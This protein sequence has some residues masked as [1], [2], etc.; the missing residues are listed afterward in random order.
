MRA[1][2]EPT[3]V[4]LFL[5]VAM[6]AAAGEPVLAQRS[7]GGPPGE[8]ARGGGPPDGGHRPPQSSD[9]G[10]RG[11][12]RSRGGYWSSSDGR[13]RLERYEAFVASM[14]TNRNG[15]IE[16]NEAQGGRGRMIR[17]LA[18]RAKIDGKF[19][20]SISR[21][22]EGLKKNYENR[23]ESK[24]KPKSEDKSSKEK[25]LVPAFGI[26][27]EEMPPVLEFGKAPP[28]AKTSSKAK[29]SSDPKSASS[30][31][32][33]SGSDDRMKRW[34]ESIIK[35]H[36]KN[37]NGKLE[38]DEWG[39]LRGDPK[40]TDRN[41][42]GV[43]TLD[44]MTERLNAYRRGRSRGEPSSRSSPRKSRSSSSDSDDSDGRKFYRSLTATERLPE[45]I[46]SWFV[47][48]DANGDG[49]VAMAEYSSRWTVSL[50]KRFT[51]IDRNGDGV[52]TPKESL[53]GP[54]QAVAP[55]K[56]DEPA[57]TTAATAKPE[58]TAK[59]ETTAKPE[60]KDQSGGMWEGW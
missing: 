38:K 15:R 50:A 13:S 30:S 35:Q 32:S 1:N 28:T 21:L 17:R 20:I 16:E 57:E 5:S 45:D 19:P 27:Q 23:D 7:R 43:I 14:D 2:W 24:S 53:E 11:S 48:K 3:I 12:G 6:V 52:I 49:Q 54:T 4:T 51:A 46:P 33:N 8:R 10:D 60:T 40:E 41:H 31:S 25:P 34:A 37:R 39:G 36:D 18:E 26:E 58:T 29:P 42:D 47:Q 9:G 44:E 56:T 22:R 55:S 59:S